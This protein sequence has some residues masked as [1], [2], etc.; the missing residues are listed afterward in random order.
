MSSDLLASQR[1]PSQGAR[2][3]PK[4]RYFFWL[5]YFNDI[6]TYNMH[7]YQYK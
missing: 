6:D 3:S 4:E 1:S 2:V 7:Y 5:P